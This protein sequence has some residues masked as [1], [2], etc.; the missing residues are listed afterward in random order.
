MEGEDS[1]DSLQSGRYS[2][3]K[4]LWEGGKGIVYRAH[5]NT[6]D[7]VVAIKMLKSETF[8]EETYEPFM[9]EAQSAA[10]AFN[11]SARCRGFS[12]PEW[13]GIP[14]TLV[15]FP[16]EWDGLSFSVLLECLG[17]GLLVV[18]RHL[19][20]QGVFDRVEPFTD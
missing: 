9:R 20:R 6:L 18:F 8:D 19:L 15:A 10:R 17:T 12:L 16:D 1:T 14:S 2:L 5:D 11:L 4:K 7:R 3:L 13:T